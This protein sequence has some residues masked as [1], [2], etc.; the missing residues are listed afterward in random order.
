MTEVYSYRVKGDQHGRIVEKKETVAG[1]QVTWNY[2]YDDAGRL[3]QAHLDDRLIF[4]GYYDNEGRRMRD[5]LPVTVGPR[6][7]DYRYTTDN[8]LQAAGNSGYTHD[9]NGFR[10][11]WANGGTYHLYEYAP[12][13]RLLSMKIENQDHVVTFLHDDNGQRVAKQ[14]NGQTVEVYQWLDFLRLAAF[15]DGGVGYEFEYENDERLPSAMRREDGAVYTLHYD[16]V[17]SL[18]VVADSANNVIKEILY[19]PFG[20]I[21]RDTNPDIRVPIGFAGGLHDRN[22]GFVRFGWRDY[23][24]FT[25]RWTA[26]DPIGDA[27]GDPDW[28]GYCLDD[29]VNAHDPN[30]LMGV[31]APLIIGKTLVTAIA[32][33]G[34]YGAAKGVDLLGENIDE[35]YGKDKPTATEGVH[36]SMKKV[37]GIQAG[38]VG[39][40]V[41]GAGGAAVARFGRLNPGYVAT[42]TELIDGAFNSG[43]PPQSSA[44]ILGL[45][46]KETIDRLEEWRKRR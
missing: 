10:C 16:Q 26:P 2:S 28:Y 41:L 45:G 12:D 19:D 8:R 40:G 39:A 1:R 25:G 46:V 36:D 31:I 37:A 32:G 29:P 14:L 30:G 27:G 20:G 13:Y 5:Y 17:G 23:D 34:L 4:Q 43:Q 3:F 33:T 7:R 22:L 9:A 35:N 18:R 21:I 38:T 24:P 42:A 15:H 11:I 6:F 44:G